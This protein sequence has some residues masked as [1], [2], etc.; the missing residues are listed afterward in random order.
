M[1]NDT[2]N[3]VKLISGLM[4]RHKHVL[5]RGEESTEQNNFASQS[6]ASAR[7]LIG[8]GRLLRRRTGDIF[9]PIGLI[10]Q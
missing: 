9:G 4:A 8:L 6:L 2:I 5:P 10:T 3:P 1:L 7:L